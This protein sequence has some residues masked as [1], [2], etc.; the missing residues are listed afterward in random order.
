[1]HCWW[2]YIL[3]VLSWKAV[4]RFLKI[5]KVELPCDPTI[6]LV[7]IYPKEMKML[8]EKRYMQPHVHCSTITLAKIRKQPMFTDKWTHTEKYIYT[9][10]WWLPWW[11]TYIF[12]KSLLRSLVIDINEPLIRKL[13]SHTFIIL[14]Y[15][16]YDFVI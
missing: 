15:Q 6:P 8:T 1:M 14:R 12:K 2:E 4:W 11:Y 7:D 10:I 16:V 5:L 9:Y 13:S 3:V